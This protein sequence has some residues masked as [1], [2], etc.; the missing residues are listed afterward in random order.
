MKTLNT[1]DN[2][3]YM[4][5]KMIVDKVS[6]KVSEFT[7]FSDSEFKDTDW[8]LKSKLAEIITQLG[9]KKE[10]TYQLKQTIEGNRDDGR[11]PQDGKAIKITIEDPNVSIAYYSDS[12]Q[13]KEEK[14]RLTHRYT[15]DK[16]VFDAYILVMQN[17]IDVSEKEKE[18]KSIKNSSLQLD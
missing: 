17:D 3:S 4:R 1:N 14:W 6:G 11:K 9:D 16:K 13:I 12:S 10:V 7:V 5:Q 15:I 8:S 2:R 18:Q